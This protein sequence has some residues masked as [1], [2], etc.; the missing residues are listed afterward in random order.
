MPIASRAVTTTPGEASKRPY[1]SCT[2]GQ[3]RSSISSE[4]GSSAS[5]ARSGR[6]GA[7]NVSC[8]RL[9]L[10]SAPRQRCEVP[11]IAAGMISASVVQALGSAAYSG[12]S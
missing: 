4:A 12:C 6:T 7:R 8:T 2:A 5:A 10:G 9:S 1:S 3:T 11:V